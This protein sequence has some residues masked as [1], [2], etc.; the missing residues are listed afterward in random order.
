MVERMR[1]KAYLAGPDVFRKDAKAYFLEL[2]K[3]CKEHGVEPLVPLDNELNKTT[4]NVPLSEQIYWGNVE[5]IKHAD[6][7]I[8]NICPFRGPS[9]D[10]GTAFEIGYARALG[11]KVYLYTPT[12]SEYRD[13]VKVKVKSEYQEIENFRL[14]DNLMIIHGSTAPFSTFLEALQALQLDIYREKFIAV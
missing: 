6:V 1:V 11:K 12:H 13:R 4:Q 8:A 2:K 10:P 5:M 14:I 7:V 3:K 9:V